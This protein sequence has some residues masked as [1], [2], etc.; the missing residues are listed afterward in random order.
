MKREGIKLSTL[1]LKSVTGL[2][3]MHCY[4]EEEAITIQG[5][6]RNFKY[7][8]S[9]TSKKGIMMLSKILK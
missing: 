3:N 7:H 8:R 2:F 6:K 5:E 9:K 1:S 4:K